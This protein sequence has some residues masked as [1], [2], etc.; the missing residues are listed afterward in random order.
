MNSIINRLRVASDYLNRRDV[1]TGMPIEFSIELTSKCNLKCIMCPRDDDTFRG[2]GYMKFDTFRRIIDEASEYLEFTYL[3]LSG[4][5]LLHPRFDEFINYAASKGVKTGISTNGTILTKRR[6]EKL[7]QSQLD[8]LIIS[9]DGTD[10]ETYLTIRQANSFR[11]VCRNTEQ[12]LIEK[13]KTNQGPHTIVQMICM[14]E[15]V[16]QAEEFYRYWKSIGADSVRLKRFFNFAG[17]VED[18]S[19]TP[20]KESVMSEKKR[21]PCFL[22]W[23]QLA[24]YYDGTAVACCHDFL[25]ESELGN[26]HQQSL[27]SIWNSEEM[28]KI[29]NKHLEGRQCDIS[30]C[31]NCNQPRA[32]LMSVMGVT[33]MNART[34]KGALVAAE[35][36]SRRLG[37]PLPY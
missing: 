18:R 34:A 26:I 37:R 19:V 8:T 21:P 9:I 25:H 16:H 23:R 7:L 35:R 3:H 29:R 31:A 10:A 15:N 30:L 13:E 12:F 14:Q 22:P 36:I 5:P 6:R 24:F 17:N 1:C 4:E 28:V 20:E 32:S 11:K 33:A 2:L 27:K